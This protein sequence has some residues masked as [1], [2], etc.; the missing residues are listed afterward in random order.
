LAALL[1]MPLAIAACENKVT[2]ETYDKIEVGMTKV[3]VERLFGGKGT[4][5]TPAAGVDIS[6]G[7]VATQKEVDE[8]IFSWKGANGEQVSITFKDGK[9]VAKTQNGFTD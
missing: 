2:K 1:A 6:G 7:G 5:D 4:D 9:V 8:K 3:Q